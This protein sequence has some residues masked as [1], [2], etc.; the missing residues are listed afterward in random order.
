MNILLTEKLD[1]CYLLRTGTFFAV[2]LT[3]LLSGSVRAAQS[4]AVERPLLPGRVRQAVES[5]KAKSV[6]DISLIPTSGCELALMTSTQRLTLVLFL[7]FN[8]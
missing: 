1:W 4:T 8:L 2:V 5:A 3:T 6:K 7:L